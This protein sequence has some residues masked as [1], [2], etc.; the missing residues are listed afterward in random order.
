MGGHPVMLLHPEL[1]AMGGAVMALLFLGFR[2]QGRR[3]RHLAD[4]LGGPPAVLRVARFDLYS[5]R[6]A[7]IVALALA[8]LLV[9]LAASEPQRLEEP[10][11]GAPEMPKRV[12]LAVDVSTSMQAGDLE[13]TRLATAME[14]ARELVDRADESQVG[15]LLFAG[16][17]YVLAPLTSDL[18]AVRF[19]L[20]G[21]AP[22][23]MSPQ[24]PGS[25]LSSG[26][27]EGVA[28]LEGS[29][30]EAERVLIVMSDGEAGQPESEVIGA[31]RDARAR[32]IVVHAI[33]VGTEEGDEVASRRRSGGAASATLS[34]GNISRLQEPLLERIA[35][36]GGG[37]YARAGDGFGL[38]RVARAVESR[39]PTVGASANLAGGTFA[40]ALVAVSL[41]LFL[42]DSLIEEGRERRPP[43]PSGRK[44]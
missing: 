31:V 3:L 15:V 6:N 44:G 10:V 35:S 34:G 1:L 16:K 42:L 23:L 40:S 24:D 13:P 20:D 37:E 29:P 11:D 33:G 5:R 30:G 25:L 22:T 36:A 21:V 17:S 26:I 14:V 4:H 27:R 38:D 41:V 32:G 8:T 9:A 12:I 39:T 7:R 19:L 28:L 18:R 2:S 43:V